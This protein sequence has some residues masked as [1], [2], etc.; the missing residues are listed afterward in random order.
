MTAEEDDGGRAAE[1]LL[2]TFTEELLTTA[3]ELAGFFSEEELAGVLTEELAGFAEELE[4]FSELL[5]SA[6][7][8][9]LTRFAEELLANFFEDELFACFTDD[10][11]SESFTEEEL[12]SSNSLSTA[13]TDTTCRSSEQ[14]NKASARD[15]AAA[16][17]ADF[18]NNINTP[19]S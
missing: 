7:E 15:A 2:A 11:D 1:E 6:T 9:E 5:E 8:E 18:F 16:N 4:F 19:Y 14:P 10:E 3:E 17:F 12:S 13:L